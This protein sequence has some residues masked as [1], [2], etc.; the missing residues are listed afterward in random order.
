MKK[1][2]LIIFSFVATCNLAVSQPFTCANASFGG[3]SG[4][5]QNIV[6]AAGLGTYCAPVT[7]NWYLEFGATIPAG[8]NVQILVDWDD[9]EFSTFDAVLQSGRWVIAN[10][11]GDAFGIFP[12]INNAKHIYQ[13]ETDGV[14]F[15]ETTAR[16]I[17]DGNVCPASTIF[18]T[19]VINYWDTDE[20]APGNVA[21]EPILYQVCAGDQVTLTFDDATTFNCVEPSTTDIP[22]QDLRN[23]R[24]TYN[25]S[26]GPTPG[27]GRIDNV[28]LSD[29][30]LIDQANPADDDYPGVLETYP[31]NVGPGDNTSTSLGITV[32]A[33]AAIGQVFEVKIENW[34]PCNPFGGAKPA[35]ERYA[36]IEIVAPPLNPSFTISSDANGNNLK[37]IFCPGEN[38]RFRGN[39]SNHNNNFVYRWEVFDNPTGA[40][41]PVW[42]RNNDR[43][44]WLSDGGT[45]LNNVFSGPGFKLVRMFVRNSDTNF[46][47]NCEVFVDRQIEIVSSPVATIGFDAGAGIVN[48]G[49]YEICLEDIGPSLDISLFDQSTLKN[50]SST[51]EW[52]IEKIVPGPT[53]LIDFRNGPAGAAA[54][55]Y[56]VNPFSITDAGEYRVRLRIEDG[57]TNCTSTD[58]LIIRVYDTP[59]SAFDTNEICE[60]DVA[61]DNRTRFF[62][63]ADNL[64]GISPRVNNDE[65]DRW[66]WD[67]SYDATAG[68]NIERDVDNNNNFR[69]F[70]DGTN[71]GE[72]TASVAGTYVV[73]LVVE[74]AFGCTDTLVQNVVVKANP[75]SDIEAIYTNDYLTNSAGDTYTGDP[76]C[77]GTF[78]TFINSSDE[79]LNVDPSLIPVT[80]ELEIEDFSG[81]ITTQ[82]IG[83]PGTATEFIETNAF[84]NSTASNQIYKVR[85]IATGDNSCPT[86]SPEIEV[87][88]LPG[89]DANFLIFDGVPGD[90]GTSPY[91]P[92]AI[93]CSPYDFYFETDANTQTYGA[94]Q[95]I[96]TVTDAGTG[97]VF[98]STTVN[99]ATDPN[100]EQFTTNFT[101][102]FPS[103]ATRFFDVTLDVITGSFCV[104]SVT[105]TVKIEP[106]PTANFTLEQT[107]ETCPTVTLRFRAEQLGLGAYNWVVTNGASAVASTVGDTP[108]GNSIFVVEFN[109]PAFGD[110][111]LN[112]TVELTTAS[113]VGCPSLPETFSG[114]IAETEQILVNTVF[115]PASGSS[116]LPA[117]YDFQ[118]NTPSIPAGTTWAFEIRKEIVPASGVFVLQET[119]EGV[120]YTGNEDFST[121]IQYEFTSPGLYQVDLLSTANSQCIFQLST[122]QEIEIFD[123]PEVRFK[124]NINEGCSPLSTVVIQENSRN[125]AGTSE[126]FNMWFEVDSAGTVIQSTTAT[127]ITGTGGQL[128][129]T[130][131]QPLL[132]PSSS[133]VDFFDYDITVFAEN[134]AGCVDDSTYTVRVFK[135]P[136]IEFQVN[137]PNPA[138]EEDYEF[139]FGIST[140]EVPTT[141]TTYRWNFGDGVTRIETDPNLVQL[142]QYINRN[143]SGGSDTYTVSVTAETAEGCSYTATETITLNP[144]VRPGF[145][146]LNDSGCSPFDLQIRGNAQG[147]GIA[148][149]IVYETRLQGAPTWTPFTGT[150]AS[151]GDAII[152]FV[153]TSGSPGVNQI[154]EIRQTV[155]GNGPCS[156][157]SP[158]QLFTVFPK[159][160]TPTITGASIVCENEMNVEFSVPHVAGNNYEWNLPEFAFISSTNAE[161]NLI[162]V[163]FGPTPSNPTPE[164]RVTITDNNFCRSDVASL[165]VVVV[166]GPT[167][168]LTLS[169]PGTICPNESTFLQVNLTGPGTLNY[170]VT[171]YDGFTETTLLD[172]SNGHPYE[173]SPTLSTNYRIT[174]I[175]DRQY[176]SCPGRPATNDIRVNVNNAPTA[177]IA[178]DATICEGEST[179]L[180]I[181][182][183]G[184]APWDVTYTD[185]VNPAITITS[186]SSALLVP[187]SP[188]TNTTYSLVSVSDASCD[189][190][191]TANTVNIIVNPAP[192]GSLFVEGD[193]GTVCI[194]TPIE[195][196]VLLTG[197]GPWTVNYEDDEGNQFAIPDIQEGADHASNGFTIHLFDVIPQKQ[198]TIY[199]IVS[200]VDVNGCSGPGIDDLTITTLPTPVLRM[201]NNV[202]ICEGES[203]NLEFNFLDGVAPFTVDVAIND[204][205][206]TIRFEDIPN[207][208]VEIISPSETTNYRAVSVTDANGCP[209]YDLGLPVRVRVRTRPTVI[210]EGQDSIC[211]GEETPLTFT[212]TGVGP[213]TITYTDGTSNFT[214]TTPFNRHFEDVSPLVSTQYSVVSI[215]DANVP[216]CSNTGSGMAEIIVAPELQADFTATPVNMSLP[217]RTVTI[218]NTTTNKNAWTYIWDFG[219]STTSTAVDP[220]P[221]VYD[222]YGTYFLRMTATNGE[223]TDIAQTII[224]IEAIPAIVDFVGDPIEGC[225]PLTVNFENLTQF[226]EDSSY[227][228]SFGDNQSAR[229]INPIHTYTRPGVYTVKLSANNITGVAQEEEKIQY[230]RVFDT[231]QS[232]FS[233]R[234]GFEQVFTGDRVEFSNSSVSAD[235]YLWDFGDGNESSE[236]E[237]V[238]VYADSGI[239]NI[240]MIAI[241]SATGCV[242]TLRKN[243]QVL[244][245]GSGEVKIPNAFTP[246]RA[247]VGTGRPEAQYNDFFLP[248]ARGVSEYDLK[249]Y[250]RWGELL[251]ESNDSQVGWDGYFKGV[252]MPMGVYVY[253]LE[254]VYENG[255]REVKLGDVTLIR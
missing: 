153:N 15:Y 133:L 163:N 193:D 222:T 235:Q 188:T 107:V 127:P 10:G 154:Y 255:R 198:N 86:V 111:D 136:F 196:G 38:M 5:F 139:S 24:W 155:T 194:N 206:D 47:G 17:I 138:C 220:E 65:I 90:A 225:L 85:I 98:T 141:G 73:A 151:N 203:A 1:L 191:V 117:V 132:N 149:N 186:N 33:T 113:V 234:K 44:T 237:P 3:G 190:T 250:N 172:I 144:T 224:T 100:P 254:L 81:G 13:D 68:F 207:G 137:S 37:T 101:N 28:L 118:N 169:G 27:V 238:H 146:R 36:L 167:G 223:C 231:P 162:R 232:N 116:C 108:P 189:G 145:I 148:G 88:V 69:R 161:R 57:S 187:V 115:S 174:A 58:E 166:N 195:I 171:I 41:A 130:L 63:I 51:T 106:Q 185:G 247:G 104:N 208:Y 2:L 129:S 70:L 140:N 110:G 214:F 12:A 66:I 125:T 84:S 61:P 192:S 227:L 159:P 211:F 147:T 40:G 173:I 96:W 123:T 226:A 62:D 82:P 92:G 246:S 91:S 8:A 87:E 119:L 121:A 39:A 156:R 251:F 216:A 67:F 49:L 252:L 213:W 89:A 170:D 18:G 217:D 56:P 197:N 80:Y 152:E 78:L 184:L 109:R 218:T 74:T 241:N 59:T 175:V 131:V 181:N 112:Y 245:I 120:D 142:K 77:P 124:T 182:M 83:A 79:S 4:N 212:S 23:I 126:P 52:V 239:Y 48:D 95:Y 71:G 114:T 180:R 221:H 14:C 176:P 179:D 42:T 6:G 200:V 204:V 205:D 229:V 93:Y 43:Y 240:Q 29:G 50:V 215:S 202:T 75:Q 210:L 103:T 209:A 25:T 53:V 46:E 244:V 22:N 11:N 134:A 54:F 35:I 164:V 99:T 168:S 94:T 34:G 236:F 199:S 30:K 165:P 177:T 45:N 178:G 21:I 150:V 230:I 243:A 7:V 122:P 60:G 9:G 19:N 253:R 248:Q 31:A 183:S 16:L 219:D 143:Q 160:E 102:A 158:V 97:A 201:T 128:N 26:D 64:S 32:P 242:D 20:D 233:V 76:I 135:K 55:D 105:K 228:W 249:I 157:T 72:P